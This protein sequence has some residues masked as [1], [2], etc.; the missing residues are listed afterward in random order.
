MSW[1]PRPG[2]PGWGPGRMLEAAGRSREEGFPPGRVALTFGVRSGGR[3]GNALLGGK[4]C[5]L[6]IGSSPRLW[7]GP[8]VL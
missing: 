4:S 5:S 8:Q 2:G 3:G 7:G 6:G 1:D